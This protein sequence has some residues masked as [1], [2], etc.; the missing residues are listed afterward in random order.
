MTTKLLRAIKFTSSS[1]L[2]NSWTYNVRV[3]HG[4]VIATG[5]SKS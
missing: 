2:L 1:I 5:Q 4:V 3:I